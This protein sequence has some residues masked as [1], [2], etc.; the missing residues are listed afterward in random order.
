MS[1]TQ[2][3]YF[4]QQRDLENRGSSTTEKPCYLWLSQKPISKL[5]DRQIIEIHVVLKKL[6]TLEISAA[7]TKVERSLENSKQIKPYQVRSGL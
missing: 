6:T 4:M 1:Q 3:E 7:L 5:T 2:I